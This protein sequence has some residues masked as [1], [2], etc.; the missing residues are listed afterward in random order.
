MPCGTPCH[1][2]S[3]PLNLTHE[4]LVRD[5]A[6]TWLHRGRSRNPTQRAAAWR[7]SCEGI[8]CIF[9]R[10][11]HRQL[12]PKLLLQQLGFRGSSAEVGVWEG[13]QSRRILKDWPRG[14]RHLMVDPYRRFDAFCSN[15]LAK[16]GDK[17]CR[18]SQSQFDA[19]FNRTS[20]NLMREFP[21]RAV[22][23]RT[24]SLNA[25][26]ANVNKSLSFVHIDARHDYAGVSEDL[27]AWWPKLCPGG[28]LVG[29]DYTTALPTMKRA[30]SAVMK[31]AAQGGKHPVASA[32]RHFLLGFGNTSGQPRLFV[33]ADHPASFIMFK[34][35]TPPCASI[36]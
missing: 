25:S 36:D 18:K 15:Q 7:A 2:L 8:H 14:G 22:F 29:H 35:T 10:R 20:Q 19:V 5:A 34:A 4:L 28:M 27:G 13:E 12:L 9:L 1:P 26:S 33:T 30:N 3:S 11:L 32:V 21:T 16:G 24:F 31:V 17:Q 23:A 6:V